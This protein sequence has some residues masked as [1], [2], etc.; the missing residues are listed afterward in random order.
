MAFAIEPGAQALL[1]YMSP[2][3]TLLW[4]SQ[5]LGAA[6]DDSLGVQYSFYRDDHRLAPDTVSLIGKFYA[7]DSGARTFRVMQELTQALS[8][9]AP[10]SPLALPQALLYDPTHRFIAQQ[11]VEGVSYRE[12]AHRRDYRQYFRLA[13]Q[14]LGTLH[15]QEVWLD[16]P[17]RLRDHLSAL[18]Q[19]HPLT[20]AE[21]LP[22][23]RP[24]IER[25]LTT[26]GA[27]ERSWRA[28]VEP[29]P[30]H[31]NFQPRQ[32][33]YSQGRVWVIDWDHFTNGDPALD[34]ATFVVA[35]QTQLSQR[36]G[37]AIESFLEGYFADRPLGLLERVPLYAA[38][39]Y[40]RLASACF[41]QQAPGWLA[42][43]QDLLLRS[44]KC[45]DE[46]GFGR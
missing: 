2:R 18:I 16:P 33:F 37:P 22:A 43:V 8:Q 26:M 27:Q 44:A 4:D 41:R 1:A 42:N 11:R 10:R 17:T 29:A 3:K 12:L 21:R 23:H 20:L 38:L 24:L 13:G 32:L 45:L 46:K 36:R 14:A 19:P 6:D 40:L 31:R 7:D 15:A 30:I 35:L 9:A 39:A 28:Q 25:L 5:V 34:V